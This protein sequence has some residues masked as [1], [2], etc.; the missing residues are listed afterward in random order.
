MSL[1]KRSTLAQLAFAVG[2]ALN[3][4]GIRAVLTGGACANFYTNGRYQ[5]ADLD[6]VLVTRVTQAALDA[7]MKSVGFARKGD[8]YVHPKL[9]YFVEFPR[10]PLAIGDD[11]Q[12]HPVIRRSGKRRASMLSATDACRDRLAAYFHWNDRQSLAIAIEIAL[13]NRVSL[14]AIRRWS[15]R[16]GTAAQVEEFENE[17][18][19]RRSRRRR[20]SSRA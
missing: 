15:K 1:T 20:H 6:F 12:I 11:S 7:A 13:G 19:R 2:D 9:S 14:T 17:L 18:E 16:E 3:R 5:S 10:G 8:C 4:N